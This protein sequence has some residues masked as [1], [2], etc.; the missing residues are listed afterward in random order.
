MWPSLFHYAVNIRREWFAA[1][2]DVLRETCH[3]CFYILPKR[4]SSKA[5]RPF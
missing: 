5:Q 3:I 4:I 1:V 2:L